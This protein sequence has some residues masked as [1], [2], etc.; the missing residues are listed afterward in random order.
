MNL[1]DSLEQNPFF[2]GGLSLM[3][4]GAIGAILRHLPMR[5][6]NFLERRISI[7]VEVPDRDPAF[8]WVQT[9]LAAGRYARRARDLSLATE[10]ISSEPDPEISPYGDQ[11]AGPASE[12]KFVLTPAPGIHLTTFRGRIL[13]VHRNRRD[14]QSGG[15]TAFQESLILQILGGSRKLIDELLA[16]AHSYSFP[17]APGVSIL[18]ARNELWCPASW[19]PKRPLA[20][21]ILADS[22]LEDTLEDL[23]DFYRS[24]AWYAERGIPYRRGYLLHGPPGTGKTTLVLALAGELKLPVATLSL[25]SRL[26]SDESLRAMVDGLPAAAFL[27]I[28]DIDCAF[29]EC[30]STTVAAGVTLSGLL[31]A[32]DG[33]SSRDG[34]VLFL[35]T[36]HPERLDPALLRAGRVDRKIELGYATPDQARRLY[37]WFFKGCGLSQSE[38]CREAERFAAQ[39]PPG[40]IGMAAIQEHL[41]RHR[42]SPGSAAHEIV[43]D[44]VGLEP[45]MAVI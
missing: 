22:I 45:Q 12:A 8:R 16:E 18:T 39:V 9:W 29:K 35:T 33:V 6:L 11:P 5:I 20:S 7:S 40:K 10:W 31:N 42:R 28:E 24:G 17:R 44:E 32:L 4:I 36:N 14:L 15:S 37:L 23:R 13:L 34:R 41:L 3:A 38:L 21:L 26:M 27:L 1:L 30:R 2:S 19:Q 43:F 25:S